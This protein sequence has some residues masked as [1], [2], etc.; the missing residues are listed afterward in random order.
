MKITYLLPV[1]LLILLA[2]FFLGLPDLRRCALPG[3]AR[4]ARSLDR[5][6]AGIMALISVVYAAIAFTGLG[7]TSSP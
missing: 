1:A 4:C 2:L 5:T 3:A 7:N 6:D